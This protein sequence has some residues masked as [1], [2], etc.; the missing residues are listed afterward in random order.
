[1]LSAARSDLDAV[2][3]VP[4]RSP[5]EWYFETSKVHAKLPHLVTVCSTN[6]SPPGL[7]AGHAISTMAAMIHGIW[8]GLL[9][10]VAGKRLQLGPSTLAGPCCFPFLAGPGS[11]PSLA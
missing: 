2:P 11:L 5:H 1:M 3:G 8:L 10:K 9:H 6:L 7:P 4:T